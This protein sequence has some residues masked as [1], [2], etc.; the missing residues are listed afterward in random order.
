MLDD[1][2]TDEL[3]EWMGWFHLQQQDKDTAT[4]EDS[5]AGSVEDG[6]ARAKQWA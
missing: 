4:M 3:V 2:S 5:L 1:L 6:L